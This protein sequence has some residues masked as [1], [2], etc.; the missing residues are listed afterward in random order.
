MFIQRSQKMLAPPIRIP[1]AFDDPGLVLSLVHA[2]APY[3]TITAVHKNPPNESTPG[4]FRNFWALG[5]KLVFDGAGD[6]FHNPRFIAAARQSFQAEIIQPLTMMTNLN[7]PAPSSPPHLDLPFFRGTHQREVP[8]WI[9]EPMGES[10][11]FQAWAI[12]VASAISWFYDGSGGD[13]EYWPDGFNS[14]SQTVRPPYSNT[15]VL[16]DNEYMYHRV[17]LTGSEDEYL[18]EGIPSESLLLRQP[19]GWEIKHRD[20]SL[21]TFTDKQIRISILWKAFCF[22][23]QYAADAF[24][25]PVNNLT[26]EMV[27]DIFC[28]DL[29]I[30]GLGSSQPSDLMTDRDWMKLVM[31][32]YRAPEGAAY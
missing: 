10:G 21:R 24:L 6:M 3:K 30:R 4:W 32:T 11:L 18:A 1:R 12:P 17:G 8:S 15:S 20:Q 7:V 2:G 27:V 14:P 13:F 23:D 9:L 19:G 22:E 16:A 26:P 29:Q 5:G 25:D 31:D 28:E